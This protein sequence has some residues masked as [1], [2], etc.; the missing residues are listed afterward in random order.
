MFLHKIL[1][2]L[3]CFF[4]SSSLYGQNYSVTKQYTY[5]EGLPSN[6]VLNIYM[7]SRNFLW[8]GTRFGVFVKDMDRFKKLTRLDELEF[9]NVLSITEDKEKR[10]WFA[11]SVEGLVMFDGEF[12][13]KIDQKNGLVSNRVREIFTHKNNLYVAT[14][15]GV[16]IINTKDLSIK[17]PSFFKNDNLSFEAVDFIEDKDKIYVVT[18]NHGIYEIKGNHLIL[19]NPYSSILNSYLENDKL[20]LSGN[21]GI[22]IFDFKS[23]LA[24]KEPIRSLSYP[25]IWDIIRYD[26]STYYFTVYDMISGNGSVRQWKNGVTTIKDKDFNIETQFPKQLEI[27]RENNKLYIA[28][29]DQGIYEV[30]LNSVLEFKTIDH[31]N[32]IGLHRNPKFKTILTSEGLYTKDNED[33]VAHVRTVDDFKKYT[34]SK[35]QNSKKT[36]NNRANYFEINHEFPKDRIKFFELSFHK[37]TYWV[38]S[39]IGLFQLGIEGNFLNYYPIITYHFTFLKDQLIEISSFSGIKV[40]KDLDR[41]KFDYF[42]ESQSNIPS[43]V[44]SISSSNQAVFFGTASDGLFKYEDGEFISYLQN[45]QFDQTKI[46]YVKSVGNNQL[47]VA[48]D[49]GRVFLFK[50]VG[51]VLIKEKVINIRQVGGESINFLEKISEQIIIGTNR[52]LLIYDKDKVYIIDDDQGYRSKNVNTVY[53]NEEEEL[54]IGVEKGYFIVNIKKIV[55]EKD[56]EIKL[57]ITSVKINDQK[58]SRENYYWF[59]LKVKKLLLENNQNNVNIDF[60]IVNA[61]F[62][63][64]FIYR[65]RLNKSEKWSDY[66]NDDFVNFKYL[67]HGHYFIQLEVMDLNSSKRKVIDLMDLNISPPYYL[68]WWFI[69]SIIS[70]VLGIIFLLYKNKIQTINKINALEIDKIRQ[71]N[72]IEDKRKML[73]QKLLETRLYALQ[74]QMNPHFIFNVL[75]SI[76]F[77]IIDNDVENALNSLGRFSHLIRQMLNISTKNNVTLKE[78]IAFLKLYA[79][80]ENSRRKYPVSLSFSIDLSIDSAQINLP[81]MIVQPILENAF[82]HAFDSEISNPTISISVGVSGEQFS[83]I[84][85]DNGNGIDLSKQKNPK[86]PS[87]AMKIVRERLQLFNRS[88]KDFIE[89][90]TSKEGT[91]VKIIFLKA[92]LNSKDEV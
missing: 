65:V 56:P 35:K 79:E 3:C 72:Y 45:S 30:I 49:F 83:L 33:Q 16:S 37:N 31:Q 89:I 57:I 50:I 32:V 71:L 41:L 63:H 51:D 74:S 60:S 62:P 18:L 68:T 13:T 39:S 66:F 10:L 36:I 12:T 8:V 55:E 42:S 58:L 53:V 90:V 6:E 28:T 48:T 1:F 11:S 7:D 88:N 23:F 43:G 86:Y 29:L 5:N 73:Q 15:G 69:V 17:N 91:N 85:S 19:V 44:T 87:K 75:N 25:V 78:E 14:L 24:K 52:N 34:L 67:K 9:N 22:S 2:Y 54:L 21:T 76:Q 61:K 46:S 26:Y 64:K 92:F 80:V 40:Y 59:D 20:Y 84:I 4:W 47:L 81:P 82:V 38:S 27:D 77:Y 70:I